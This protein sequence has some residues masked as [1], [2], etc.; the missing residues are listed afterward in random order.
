MSES[1][2]RL[3]RIKCGD[4]SKWSSIGQWVV[5][6]G[7]R[8]HWRAPCTNCIKF[9]AYHLSFGTF[10]R[11][12]R[13]RFLCC[14]F[15]AY[16]APPCAGAS[17]KTEITPPER[18]FY[19]KHSFSYRVS[20]HCTLPVQPM[21]ICFFFF[22]YNWLSAAHCSL[23]GRSSRTTAMLVSIKI[24]NNNSWAIEIQIRGRFVWAQNKSKKSNR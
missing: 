4:K 12:Y 13:L 8:A 16:S 15:G 17:V 11:F 20:A 21:H 14:L 7:K 10:M 2:I 22:I 18:R 6:D 24:I 5:V 23:S 3:C 9:I 19:C 1:D